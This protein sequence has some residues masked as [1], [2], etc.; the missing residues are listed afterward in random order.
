V[1]GEASETM[2]KLCF[3]PSIVLVRKLAIYCKYLV[4]STYDRFLCARATKEGK[5]IKPTVIPS[6]SH[7]AAV[8]IRGDNDKDPRQ[9]GLL[10]GY[11]GLRSVS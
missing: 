3:W 4:H 11:L 8:F 1:P 10:L 6:K 9:R 5:N 7:S 2:A